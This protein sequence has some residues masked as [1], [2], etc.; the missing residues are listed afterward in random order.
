SMDIITG[1][2]TEMKLFVDNYRMERGTGDRE[3]SYI[4]DSLAFA[5]FDD[6]PML[7]NNFDLA[8]SKNANQ[9]ALA[10]SKL[11][12]NKISNITDSSA[13]L[14]DR[15][16]NAASMASKISPGELFGKFSDEHDFY[17]Q[18]KAEMADMALETPSI[19]QQTNG[20]SF[21]IANKMFGIHFKYSKPSQQELDNIKKYY[22]LMGYQVNL[23]GGQLDRLDSMSLC[24][25]VKFSGSLTIPGADVSLVEMM[26]AQFENGVRLWHNKNTPNPMGQNILQNVMVI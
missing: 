6:V 3:G 8:M 13:N 12:T 1:Y 11:I 19:S 9:R 21:N 23:Q 18:Q 10:E 15:F 5:Q 24:N 25:Y 16:F 4:N 14:K 26:K 17:N 7:I 20:N 22:K 2:H